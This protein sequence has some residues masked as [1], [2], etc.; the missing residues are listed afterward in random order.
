VRVASD[1]GV[2]G[3]EEELK[4]VIEKVEKEIRARLV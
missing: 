2:T 1:A 4:K 3:V